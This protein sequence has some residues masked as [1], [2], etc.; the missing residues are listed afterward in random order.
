[1]IESHE[2]PLYSES[3]DDLVEK[4]RFLVV[5]K[6]WKGTIRDE[7]CNNFLVVKKLN[8]QYLNKEGN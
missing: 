3:D 5:K 8:F 4:C 7:L 2:M 1:M 6:W